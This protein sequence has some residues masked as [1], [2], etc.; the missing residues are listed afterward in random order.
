MTEAATGREQ[1]PVAG[2]R[3]LTILGATGSIGKSTLDLVERNSAAFEIVALTAQSNVADLAS[4]ARR[5]RARLAVIG[6]A[7]KHEELRE[8]LSGTGIRT[9]A[10][11]EAVTAAA[12]ERA[13][14]VMAAIVGA[15]GLEPTFEAVRQGRRVALANKECL[16]SAG[17]VFM[18]AVAD[19]K[20]ELLPVDSEH[21]AALQALAG[22]APESIERIVLTAS[23]GPFRTWNSEELERAT[24]EQ[25]LRH[26]NW[27]M[28]AKITIDSA[29]LMNKGLELIEAY[30]L[31]P[32]SAQQLGT[33]VHPQ[34]IVHCLVSYTDGSVLAQMAFPDMRTPIALALSW[35]QRMSAPTQRLDLA[36][37]GTLSF[38]PP[39][40]K[41]FPALTI[42]RDALLRGGTA[43]A[44]L[45]A[46]NEV[47]VEAFLSRQIGFLDIVRVVAETLEAAEARG[48]IITAGSLA[49][50]LAADAEGRRLARDVLVRYV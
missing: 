2:P 18:S 35:P 33:V 11:P 24:P 17:D 44:I 13:D 21:S 22:A 28:G 20:A 5:T 47:A 48:A 4:A 14:C 30:H 23:G 43:P 16:V 49:E 36:A 38:E 45:S 25:A 37:V 9:A 12:A 3:T 1:V 15:A 42:A 50:V 19:A 46:A 41:R 32:V 34:S 10:G 29:T 26:P 27:S 7:S 40:E 6:D 39:D 31:F 8:A